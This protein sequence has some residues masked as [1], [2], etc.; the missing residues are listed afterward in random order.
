MLKN[1]LLKINWTCYEQH[2]GVL[3]ASSVSYVSLSTCDHLS[4]YCSSATSSSLGYDTAKLWVWTRLLWQQL[5]CENELRETLICSVHSRILYVVVWE[6]HLSSGPCSS[7]TVDMLCLALY[8]AHPSLALLPS[9]LVWPQTSCNT[10][11]MPRNPWSAG[12]MHPSSPDLLCSS[13]LSTVGLCPLLVRTLHLP[14]LSSS[15]THL[16]Y[17]WGCSC[18]SL[19]M[20]TCLQQ[21]LHLLAFNYTVWSGNL[22]LTSIGT[23]FFCSC[24]SLQNHIFNWLTINFVFPIFQLPR[25]KAMQLKGCRLYELLHKKTDWNP[26]AKDS[27]FSYALKWRKYPDGSMCSWAFLSHRLS[28]SHKLHLP[29]SHS[30]LAKPRLLKLQYMASLFQTMNHCISNS[31]KIRILSEL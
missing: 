4:P 16:P 5:S 21:S 28:S 26:A 3:S 19:A 2:G 30:Q 1:K 9:L 22:L 29:S 13:C 6:P 10:T 24:R 12:H 15:A 7:Y 14:T 31:K 20:H 27:S 25:L 11:E 8:L 17:R 18:C 23:S